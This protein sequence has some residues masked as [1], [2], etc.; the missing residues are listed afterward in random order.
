MMPSQPM[1]PSCNAAIGNPHSVPNSPIG[2]PDFDHSHNTSHS[3]NGSGSNMGY[4]QTMQQRQR[5]IRLMQQ[6]QFQQQMQQN[7][8]MMNACNHQQS[9]PQHGNRTCRSGCNCDVAP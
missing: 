4:P 2:V 1:A 9:T 3:S 6:Q 5:N 7:Q 8:G